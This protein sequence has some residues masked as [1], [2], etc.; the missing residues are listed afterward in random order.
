M[1]MAAQRPPKPAF[2]SLQ[3]FLNR[4]AV[5]AQYRQ[6][7]RITK[8]LE[9]D[10]RRDVR[11]QI[12]ASYEMYRHV[13]DETQASNLLRQGKEQVKHVSDLVDS[14]VARQRLVEETAQA[15]AKASVVVSSTSKA[16]WTDAASGEDDD[17]QEDVRGRL[18]TGWP[19]KKDAPAK[20]LELD[21]VR[22][23]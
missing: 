3:Y 2:K 7:L 11:Q 13:E 18:G 20:K 17:D 1:T 9:R 4:S 16:T 23:R 12:R 21:G 22:R 6:L 8:P 5:L 19:W 15:K 10:V 14:A